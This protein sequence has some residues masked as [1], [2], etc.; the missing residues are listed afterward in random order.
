[1]PVYKTKN[2][3]KDGRQWYFATYYTDIFDNRKKYKSKKYASREEAKDEEAL[4][5]IK[6]KT[7]P[8]NSICFK[9]LWLDYYNTSK[10]QLKLSSCYSNES[11][12]RLYILPYFKDKR[13][14]NITINDVKKWQDEML[15]KKLSKKNLTK[16]HTLLTTILNFGIK[17]YELEKNTASLNGN[18][19]IPDKVKED[20][21]F[22]SLDEFNQFISIIDDPAYFLFFNIAF[23]TGMRRG[24]IRALIWND[25]EK[26]VIKIRKSLSEKIKNNEENNTTKTYSSSRNIKIPNKLVILLDNELKRQKQ[27]KNFK[28]EWYVIGAIEPIATTTLDN[29]FKRYIKESKVKPIRIHDL[30]HSHASLLISKG[31]DITIVAE[32]LG[33]KNKEMT[34]NIYSHMCK[35]RQDEILKLIDE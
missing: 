2:K 7:P 12:A 32:R 8:S 9:E 17:Y 35:N 31:A 33:H 23:Y 30:R 21:K 3:T 22:W 11:I 28:N 19:K 5:I 16:I 14:K 24:E 1:M 6:S 27:Y 15:L 18:F 34:L 13:I 20:I 26:D 25:I 10:K 29:R 4:F